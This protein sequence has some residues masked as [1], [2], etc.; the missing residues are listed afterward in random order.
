MSGDITQENSGTFLRFMPSMNGSFVPLIVTTRTVCLLF[1][2]SHRQHC[3][4]CVHHSTCID[5]P[6]QSSSDERHE[7]T[8]DEQTSVRV[9][10]RSTSPIGV[11]GVGAVLQ[12]EV[13]VRGTGTRTDVG[14]RPSTEA[15]AVV[16]VGQQV[17]VT[18][19]APDRLTAHWQT[20]DSSTPRSFTLWRWNEQN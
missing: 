10:S 3:H 14:R 4:C 17:G 6:I 7:T 12:S 8:M 15:A 13:Q 11:C 1:I 9:V 20:T 2:L 5:R 18:Q 19:R 16:V